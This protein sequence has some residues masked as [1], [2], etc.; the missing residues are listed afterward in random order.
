M[1]GEEMV[2]WMVVWLGLVLVASPEVLALRFHI[3][4]NTKRCLKEEMRKNTLVT[5]EYEMSEAPGQRTDLQ[6]TDS[7]GHTAFARESIDKGKFAVIADEDDIYDICLISYLQHG[8]IQQP[9]EVSLELKH[10]VEAKSYEEVRA[11][12]PCP[13]AHVS[14]S[15]SYATMC[16]TSR[17]FLLPSLRSHRSGN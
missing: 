6:I 5:G 4:P 13:P 12:R 7:K 8:Q 3:Q 14:C 16:H 9:R 15:T 10:G 1:F 17:F 2:K 11:A